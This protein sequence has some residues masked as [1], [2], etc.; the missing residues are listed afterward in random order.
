MTTCLCCGGES[1]Y[2]AKFRNKNRIVRRFRCIRCGKTFSEPQQLDG[3]RIETQKVNDVVRLLCEGVGVRATSRLTGLHKHTVLSIVE[4]IGKKCARFHDANV[5]NV[6]TVNVETDELYSY[7]YCKQERNKTADPERGEQ[8]TFL[9]FCRDSK[10][11]ISFY[12]GKRTWENTHGHIHDLKD[13]LAGRVQI[14]TDNWKGYRGKTGAIQQTFGHDGVNYGML[15]K[16]YAK[17]LRPELRYSQPVCILA[18]KTPM[19]G[20]PDIGLICTSHIERQNLNVR[21]FNRRFTRLTLGYSKK[22]SNLRHSVALF[23]CYWNW[24]WKHNTTKQTPAQA[25]KLTDHA[26][27]VQELIDAVSKPEPC[28]I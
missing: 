3:L 12:T 10:L 13:R 28:T 18:K 23:V 7:V 14:S 24:C 19:L 20:Q 27:T 16:V 5:R 4:T 25:A 9:S 21:L 26:W 1:K 11:V 22:L 17:S 15:T 8:Y 6:P 2:F